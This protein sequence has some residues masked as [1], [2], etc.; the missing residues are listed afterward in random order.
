MLLVDLDHFQRALDGGIGGLKIGVAGGYFRARAL[1]EALA[2]VEGDFT[3]SAFVRGITGVDNVCERAAAAAGG[4]IIVPK[5]AN[6]GV[7]AAVARKD[8][9]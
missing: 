3:P 8:M 7:T 2:A 4:R 1:P 6:N 9:L 5:Q